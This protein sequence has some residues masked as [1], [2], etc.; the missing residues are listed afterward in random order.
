[1]VAPASLLRLIIR[2]HQ[3]KARPAKN[4][5]APAVMVQSG[6]T[7]TVASTHPKAE[8]AQR[9]GVGGRAGGVAG[10]DWSWSTPWLRGHPPLLHRGRCQPRG[11][12]QVVRV[13]MLRYMSTNAILT[14]TQRHFTA[15]PTPFFRQQLCQRVNGGAPVLPLPPSAVSTERTKNCCSALTTPLSLNNRCIVS[16]TVHAAVLPAAACLAAG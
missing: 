5:H 8:G 13:G 12:C 4:M 10:E 16:C 2:R 11:G 14:P 3:V 7:T 9:T 15:N 6:R 1:M